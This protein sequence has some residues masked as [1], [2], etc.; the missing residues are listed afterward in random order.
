MQARDDA[1]G[2][3]RTRER[4]VAR[5]LL[6]TTSCID[7]A[8]AEPLGVVQRDL[9]LSEVGRQTPSRDLVIPLGHQD[10]DVM[11]G[12]TL[13]YSPVLAVCLPSDELREARYFICAA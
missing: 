10:L 8:V 11:P 7:E 12:C 13:T 4:D 2:R 5:T 3:Q 6:G 1:L 9:G